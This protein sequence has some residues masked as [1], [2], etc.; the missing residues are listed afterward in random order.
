MSDFR[1]PRAKALMEEYL[2]AVEEFKADEAALQKL[3]L[4]YRNGDRSSVDAIK[5][6]EQKINAGR[7]ALR[8]KANAVISQEN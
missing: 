4:K 6:L 5:N 8:K 7:N 2:D 1:S 3:R